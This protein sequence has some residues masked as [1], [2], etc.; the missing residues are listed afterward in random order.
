MSQN[1]C[2]TLFIRHNTPPRRKCQAVMS[3]I[4]QI[5][6]KKRNSAPFWPPCR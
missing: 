2:L 5:S 6:P 1:C 3:Y 4:S